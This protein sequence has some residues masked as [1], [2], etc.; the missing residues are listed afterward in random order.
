[1]A[2]SWGAD[3]PISMPEPLTAD[4]QVYVDMDAFCFTLTGIA[5]NFRAAELEAY[6]TPRFAPEPWGLMGGEVG[7]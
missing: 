3:C 2:L 1:M 5:H 7:P 4:Q 6:L